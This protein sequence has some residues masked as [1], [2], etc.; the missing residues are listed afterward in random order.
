MLARP[1]HQA[2]RDLT[3]VFQHASPMAAARWAA[4]LIAHLPEC[5]KNRSLR[6]ADRS[7]EVAGAKFRT[8]TGATVTLP[9]SYTAGAREMFCRNVYLR[10]GLVMPSDGWVIDLGANR[11]L[12]SV[13]AALSGARSVSVEAQSGFGDEIRRLAVHN[14]VDD[15]VNVEVAIASGVKTSGAAVGKLADDRVW[16]ETS[17]GGPTRPADTS[18]PELLSRYGIDRVGLLK[19][20]IEGGEF[21]VLGVHEDLH[22]LQQVDQ[23]AIE[24]HDGHGD[25]V[26][27]IDRLRCEGLTVDLRDDFGDRAAAT[28]KSAA[29]AYCRRC[30]VS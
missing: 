9:G 19:I 24:L 11:G 13:W 20:D 16:S 27:L 28:S 17:H 10:T 5:A 29:Y 3:S 30:Q 2:W 23:L 18:V 26:T 7:W 25:V 8:S 14:G 4:A 15:R 22:W 1:V 21:A 12:F 6:P